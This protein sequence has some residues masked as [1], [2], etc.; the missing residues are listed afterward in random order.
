MGFDLSIFGDEQ[1]Q[2]DF[3]EWLVDERSVEIHR[4]NAEFWEYYTN[5]MVESC[6]GGASGRKVSESSRCY[7]QGQEYG[8]PARI[9]GLVHSSG[10]G[11]FGARA[12]TDVQ[13]KEVVI[14]N[15]IAWRINAA[16][17]PKSTKNQK[18]AKAVNPAC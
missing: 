16:E 7:S 14:E 8:L 17:A 10:A 11:V 4:H 5:R 12:V 15:D 1:L 13:R 9:T 18:L 3:V 6:I 2:A